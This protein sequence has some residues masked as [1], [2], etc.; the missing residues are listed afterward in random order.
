[1]D[2]HYSKNTNL[3]LILKKF[4]KSILYQYL[5]MK[6]VKQFVWEMTVD[7]RARLFKIQLA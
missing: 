1:M 6:P 3:A 5:L 7:F 2:S 4:K